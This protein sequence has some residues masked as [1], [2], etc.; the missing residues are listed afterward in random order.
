MGLSS[1]SLTSIFLGVPLWDMSGLLR[2]AEP[3]S[4]ITPIVLMSG[5]YHSE[6]AARA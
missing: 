6:M 5:S 1:Y 2:D 4:M 3:M